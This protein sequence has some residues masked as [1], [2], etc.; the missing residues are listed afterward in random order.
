MA[1]EHLRAA[2]EAKMRAVPEKVRN[3]SVQV[4]LE[5]KRWAEEAAKVLRNKYAAPSA[6]RECL[7]WYNQFDEGGDG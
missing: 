1:N 6:I 4:A 2:L 3:G 5:Y 7:A